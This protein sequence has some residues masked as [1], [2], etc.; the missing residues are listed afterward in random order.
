MPS[1]VE[2]LAPLSPPVWATTEQVYMWENKAVMPTLTTSV[3]AMYWSRMTVL[4]G[5]DSYDN[6]HYN[7]TPP[8]WNDEVNYI[9]PDTLLSNRQTIDPS[10]A[11]YVVLV[12]QPILITLI[13]VTSFVLSY[14]SIVDGSN[15]GIVAILAGVRTDTLKILEGASFSGTLQKPVGVQI[16]RTTAESEKEPR[17]EYRFYDDGSAPKSS[18]T[19]TL[20]NRFNARKKVGYHQISHVA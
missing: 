12:T 11:L 17:I 19:A 13:L 15:F 10:W 16:S 4:F 18:F 6:Q 20:R 1:L 5:P 7:V 8:A 9:T 3:A 2:Y 14:F